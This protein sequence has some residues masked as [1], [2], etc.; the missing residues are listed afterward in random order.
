[1]TPKEREAI[2]ALWSEK[3]T[4]PIGKGLEVSRF[5]SCSPGRV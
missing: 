1:M 3:V 2:A 5:V 4:L